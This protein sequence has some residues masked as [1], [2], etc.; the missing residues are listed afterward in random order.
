M[1]HCC[2]CCSVAKSCST[3][4]NPMNC[5]TPGF[6][7]LHYLPKFAQTH[8]HCHPTISSSVI[9]FYPCTQS[10]PASR[11]FPMS[12]LFVSF[13]QGIGASASA[14]VLPKNIQG[15]SC[16]IDWFD[17]LGI[18][19]GLSRVFSSTTLRKHQFLHSAFFMVQLSHLYMTTGKTMALTIWT[20]VGKVMSLLFN[21]MSRFGMTFLPGSKRLLISWLQSPPTVILEP[22]KIQYCFHIFPICLQRCDGT[23]FHDLSFLN[24]EF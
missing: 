16:R 4:C 23:G 18:S 1:I 20:F 8:V 12:W 2:C 11:S 9:P 10:F 17:L 14:A 5:S 19:K 15:S 7:V 13:G 3:L 24:V 6:P 22:K 21:T